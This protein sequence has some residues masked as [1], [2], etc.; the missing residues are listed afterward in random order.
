GL[1]GSQCNRPAGVESSAESPAPGFCLGRLRTGRRIPDRSTHLAAVINLVGQAP[2]QSRSAR[3]LRRPI[4]IVV[5]LPA[6]GV[7]MAEKGLTEEER[8]ELIG[9]L[10]G[11]VLLRRIFPLLQRL[12]PCGTERDTARN[13][14]LFYSQYAALL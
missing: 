6:E 5:F 10:A 12:A 14:Q 4:E 13:R 9:P 1:E 11:T 8:R 2:A 3:F 7:A